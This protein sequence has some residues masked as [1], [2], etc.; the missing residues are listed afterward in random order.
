MSQISPNHVVTFQPEDEPDLTIGVRPA[1]GP[2]RTEYMGEL[3]TDGAN[4]GAIAVKICRKHVRSASGLPE[5]DDFDHRDKHSFDSWQ[6]EWMFAVMG[7]VI[8]GC[9]MSGLDAKN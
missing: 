9:Q 6:P 4:I 5:V 8:E 1:T 3:G 7:F 2:Q